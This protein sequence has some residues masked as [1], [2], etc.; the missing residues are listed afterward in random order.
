MRRAIEHFLEDPLSEELLKGGF[1][2]K[3]TITVKAHG[4]EGQK[5]LFFDATT[6]ADLYENPEPGN[7]SHFFVDTA[8]SLE[9]V[10]DIQEAISRHRRARSV[11]YNHSGNRMPRWERPDGSQDRDLIPMA[12][13][14]QERAGR[15]V[16]PIIAAEL[17]PPVPG[18]IPLRT[19]SA[20]LVLP[21]ESI[22][23]RPESS[24]AKG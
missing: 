14:S 2:G 21:K 22:G 17:L 24:L 7:G 18:G 23:A 10:L 20:S 5:K 9:L 13:I 3:D 6:D 11:H 4:V 16:W 15:P 1:A 8:A 19:C 12:I